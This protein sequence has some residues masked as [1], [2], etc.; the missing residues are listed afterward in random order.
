MAGLSS[1]NGLWSGNE[2]LA[3]SAVGLWSGQE[4]LS[5]TGSSSSSP[6]LLT[7]D[8]GTDILTDDS[9]TNVLEHG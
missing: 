4:G 9:G 2:G 8:A 3:V 5:S 1:G 6:S 7:N